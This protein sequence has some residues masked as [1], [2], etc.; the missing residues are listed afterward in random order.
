MT[1]RKTRAHLE[2][3]VMH[4]RAQLD[5]LRSA[6]RSDSIVIVIRDLIK[7][8]G[9]CFIVYC[10]Y[11][12]VDSL[13][14]RATN[15]EFGFNLFSNSRF[16]DFFALM[17]GT[18]GLSYGKHQNNLRKDVIERIEKRNSILEKRL[19]PERSSS[20]LTPRGETRVEDDI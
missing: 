14:G 12:A 1:G 17:T 19:D 16:V 3:E 5:I 2:S 7:W 8:G 15:A 11:L 9:I 6:N 18:L 13:A 20:M 4:L 10:C